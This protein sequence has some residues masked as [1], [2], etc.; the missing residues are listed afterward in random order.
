MRINFYEARL[1]EDDRVI[2]VKDKT[3]DYQTEKVNTPDRIAKMM[4]ELLHMEKMA[5][6]YCYMIALNSAC[7][8]LGIFFLSK[9]T[10]N[11]SLISPRE[12]YIR[13]LLSGAVQVILCHNHPSGNAEPSDEDIKVTD[14]VKKAGELMDVRLADHVII[15]GG[16][17]Y[18]FKEERML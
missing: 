5:E 3:A 16:S 8:I 18:S 2:L 13:A 12:L 14:R 15:A 10:V 6:E 17:Y 11:F 9:G 7:R 4:R 1:S